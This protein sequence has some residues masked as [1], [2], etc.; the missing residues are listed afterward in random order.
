[1]NAL[2]A[3]IHNPDVGLLL[4]RSMVGVVGV[5]HGAQKLFG[6]WGGPGVSGFAG[7]LETLGVPLPHA[8]AVLASTAEFFGGLLLILGLFPRLAAIPF[9][10]TM[11]VAIIKVHPDTFSGAGGMEFPLTIAVVLLG[12]VFAGGGRYAVGR[13]LRRPGPK[14]NLRTA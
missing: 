3:R 2:T 7:Y 9:M 5:F 4:I 1:M 10:A 11:L 13:L 8:S 14:A 6:A 12:I